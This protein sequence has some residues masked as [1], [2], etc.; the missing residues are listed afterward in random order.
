M[1]LTWYGADYVDMLPMTSMAFRPIESLGYPGR[2]YKFFNGSTVYPF[3]HGLSYTQFNYN[4]KSSKRSLNIKL[5]K[6]QHCRNVNYSASAYKPMCPAVLIEDLKCHDNIEFEV[7]VKNVGRRDGSE[8][9]MV[10]RV[11]P[12]GIVGAPMKELI[13]FKR[14][15]VAAG[16]SKTIKFVVNACKSLGIVDYTANHLLPAGR[17]TLMIGDG[18]VSFPVNINFKY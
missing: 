18:A 7:Q 10:Y 5:H 16:R 8:V 2:T 11:P 1:P 6:L 14:V 13:T 17:H 9:V 12:E 15:S 4:L 3:G